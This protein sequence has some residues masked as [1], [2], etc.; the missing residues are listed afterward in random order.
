M[1]RPPGNRTY[2]TDGQQFFVIVNQ[3]SLKLVTLLALTC[4][5]RVSSLAKRYIN[6][7]R[8]SPEGAMF[9]L[10]TPTK[11][12]RPDETVT[13]FFSS[14]AKDVALCPVD[15]L[16]SY[17]SLTKRFRLP[18]AEEPN[19]LLISHI[20]HHSSCSD[21]CHCCSMDSFLFERSRG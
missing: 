14:F 11:T 15:C 12:S 10:T 1:G 8:F 7:H 5:K 17:M 2:E 9:T 4:P 19:I 6:H 3:L 18:S 21:H 20:K 16:K 13:A